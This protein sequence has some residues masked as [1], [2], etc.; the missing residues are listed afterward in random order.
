M[1]RSLSLTHT[2]AASIVPLVVAIP[3]WRSIA[4]VLNGMRSS[5]RRLVRHTTVTLLCNWVHCTSVTQH[6]QPSPATLSQ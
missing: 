6:T 1:K 5:T 4:N 2:A 3:H